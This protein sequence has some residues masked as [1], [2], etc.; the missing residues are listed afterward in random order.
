[1]SYWHCCRVGGVVTMLFLFSFPGRSSRSRA[2]SH[3]HSSRHSTWRNMRR[4]WRSMEGVLKQFFSI[5]EYLPGL[6]F[7]KTLHRDFFWD[8]FSYCKF[9][10]FFFFFCQM[11]SITKLR[12]K[13]HWLWH[14]DPI[15]FNN[16]YYIAG[17]SIWVYHSLCRAAYFDRLCNVLWESRSVVLWWGTQ[18][19]PSC[20]LKPGGETWFNRAMGCPRFW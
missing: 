11:S 6:V 2:K 5:W 9:N 14:L 7:A 17:V 10:S 1:M 15:G 8:F 12:N 13:R 4:W 20:Q 3:Q 18:V 16:W 19:W